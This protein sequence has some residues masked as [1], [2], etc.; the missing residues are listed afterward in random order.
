VQHGGL[1]SKITPCGTA[2]GC[3]KG[4]MAHSAFQ[5][6]AILEQLQQVTK[7][8]SDPRV[9]KRL[10]N[11]QRMEG[12]SSGMRRAFWQELLLQ[13]CPAMHKEATAEAPRWT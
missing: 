8:L 11:P 10:L 1:R 7:S 13:V 5:V 6:A 2:A 12:A 4:V 9:T 3:Q